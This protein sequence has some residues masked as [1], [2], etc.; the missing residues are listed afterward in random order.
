[1]LGAD[2]GAAVAAASGVSAN[3]VGKVLSQVIP[4]VIS[5]PLNIDGVGTQFEAQML[6]IELTLRREMPAASVATTTA[7]RRN[8]AAKTTSEGVPPAA[9]TA[10][11]KTRVAARVV[12]RAV[13]RERSPR[14]SELG[15]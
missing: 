2:K 7:A 15:V 1:M 5:K 14:R 3:H 4:N 9:R 10:T 11:A 6:D 8:T 13:S 12:A